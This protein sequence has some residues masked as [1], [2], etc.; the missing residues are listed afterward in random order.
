MKIFKEGAFLVIYLYLLPASVQWVKGD[1]LVWLGTFHYLPFLKQR[2]IS[3]SIFSF[4][5]PSCTLCYY[6]LQIFSFRICFPNSC[7]FLLSH[8]KSS[9]RIHCCVNK[10][11]G[12]VR[13]L[14]VWEHHKY[15]DHSA[16]N[17]KSL[18]L[19]PHTHNLSLYMWG[20]A[21]R[22][23]HGQFSLVLEEWTEISSMKSE[24]VTAPSS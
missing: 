14:V 24:C 11:R 2:Y 10:I 7:Y 17:H 3:K 15:V 5:C 9:I 6:I 18:L 12:A 4:L 20:V 23:L 21:R 16:V 1:H 13:L 19:L 22:L 8:S